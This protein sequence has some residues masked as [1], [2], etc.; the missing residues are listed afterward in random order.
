[1]NKELICTNC[2][3]P[4]LKKTYDGYWC[5]Y[6]HNEMSIKT[7]K[8][9]NNVSKRCFCGAEFDGIEC[10]SCGFDATEIDIY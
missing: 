10:Y 7:K 9:L 3:C 4:D 5:K 2:G 1:M 6:C 8:P